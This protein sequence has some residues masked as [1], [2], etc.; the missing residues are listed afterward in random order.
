METGDMAIGRTLE[1]MLFSCLGRFAA[2][3]PSR[4]L[5]NRVKV[6]RQLATPG[7]GKV[8]RIFG[9]LPDS[10][11]V[12]LLERLGEGSATDLIFRS[13]VR[14]VR[15]RTCWRNCLNTSRMR[16]RVSGPRRPVDGVAGP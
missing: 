11:R 14:S 16:F 1:R 9:F 8:G 5:R 10:H 12:F 3:S 6:L 15:G 2:A 7:Y 4:D 13:F